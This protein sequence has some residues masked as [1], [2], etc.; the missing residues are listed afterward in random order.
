MNGQVPVNISELGCDYFAGSPHKWMFAPAGCGLLWGREEMLDRLWVN[1]ATGGWD[2]RK[3]KAG[4][5][6]MV[7]T[8]N[9]AIF[10]GLLAGLRF[11]QALGPERV[12]AR[13]HQLARRVVEQARA[14]PQV[15]LLTPEDDRMFGGLVSFRIPGGDVNPVL[16]LCRA[17]RLWVLGS[18]ERF[19][20]ATHIHVLPADIDAFFGVLREGLKV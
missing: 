7:G 19:R 10:E 16:K 3:L 15:E 13:I 4:R 20:V 1:V 18:G 11:L 5:F 2:N 9:R 14:L 8:N 12:Y 6:M 17:R